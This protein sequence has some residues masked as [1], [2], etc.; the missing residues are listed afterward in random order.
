M[1]AVVVLPTE[2]GSPPRR[3]GRPLGS[4]GH[5]AERFRHQLAALVLMGK[6][7]SE[8]AKALDVSSKTITLWLR[9]PSVQAEIRELEAE[10]PSEHAATVRRALSTEH[11]GDEEAA[12]RQ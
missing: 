10:T 3:R 4:T 2:D 7:N 12:S 11:H 6:R 8:I 5:Q 9:H 1:N